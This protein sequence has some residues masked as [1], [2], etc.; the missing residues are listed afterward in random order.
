MNLKKFVLKIVCYC[1]DVIINFEDFAFNN[2]LIDGK[3]RK[4]ILIC[5]ILYRTLIG[6]KSLLIRFKKIDRFNKVH[7]G[8]SYLTFF[9]SEKYVI[10]KRIRYLIGV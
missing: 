9:G 4:D 8:T 2:I 1:F 5:D 6:A 7:D 3:S 10:C